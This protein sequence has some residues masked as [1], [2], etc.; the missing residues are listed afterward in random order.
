M[1]ARLRTLLLTTPAL[2]A[3]GLV[4]AWLLFGWFGFGPLAQWGAEKYVA[5]KTG[6]HLTMDQ[7]KFDP[8][9][10]E[11]TLSNVRLTEPDGQLLAGFKE[12]FVD[13]EASSL[14]HFA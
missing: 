3:I 12:L 11:L 4:V 5:D 8:L 6:H 9:G 10:L 7:P 13:F 2:V 14:F 1:L